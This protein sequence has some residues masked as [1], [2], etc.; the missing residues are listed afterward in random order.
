M[1]RRALLRSPRRLRSQRP[2]DRRKRLAV[3]PLEDR[4][5]L[6]LMSFQDGVLPTPDYNG[7]R[8][9]PLFRAEEGVNFGDE[10]ILR[11][12]AE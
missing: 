12:D 3:E 10:A 5:L 6:A 8:D 2:D 1:S 7:T 4:R 11:A 9:V